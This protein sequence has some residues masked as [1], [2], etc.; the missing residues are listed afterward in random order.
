M[1]ML[2]RIALIGPSP[3]LRDA[4]AAR[5]RPQWDGELSHQEKIGKPE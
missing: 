1:P 3:V 2:E 4:N 5:R